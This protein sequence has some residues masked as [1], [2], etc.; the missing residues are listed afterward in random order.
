MALK[1]DTQ[2]RESN[3]AGSLVVSSLCDAGLSRE[4]SSR[5]GHSNEMDWQG[6]GGSSN[7]GLGLGSGDEGRGSDRHSV[8]G[9]RG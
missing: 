3:A 8:G 7:W 1:G 6:R 5:R 2:G 4:R 9:R